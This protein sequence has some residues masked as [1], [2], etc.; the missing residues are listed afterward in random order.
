MYEISCPLVRCL[1]RL[2]AISEI[3]SNTR[4]DCSF[5]FDLSNV[6]KV[7]K[8]GPFQ[9]QTTYQ[10]CKSIFTSWPKNTV[11]AVKADKD[12]IRC[13]SR[14]SSE[15]EIFKII[16][17]YGFFSGKKCSLTATVKKKRYSFTVLSVLH[18]T[19]EYTFSNYSF[20]L[21]LK[22]TH[23]SSLFKEKQQSFI[24]NVRC[25]WWTRTSTFVPDALLCVRYSESWKTVRSCKHVNFK[26]DLEKKQPRQIKMYSQRRAQQ[27]SHITPLPLKGG[28]PDLVM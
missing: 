8:G 13:V 17:F 1:D 2:W 6:T 7:H 9:C 3:S 20:A 12:D 10:V 26:C 16:R 28:H 15:N 4:H 11:T 24:P 21:L 19:E 18:M 22:I 5:D 23:P 14:W 27:L 25:T